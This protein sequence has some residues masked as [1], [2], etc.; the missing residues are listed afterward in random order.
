[1]ACA[2]RCFWIIP[3]LATVEGFGHEMVQMLI[4][5][6]PDSTLASI[7]KSVPMRRP[8]RQSAAAAPGGSS[9]QDRHVNFVSGLAG[10]VSLLGAPIWRLRSS[11]P[12][13]TGMT[14][15]P[16]RI[17]SARRGRVAGADRRGGYSWALID[18]WSKLTD[19]RSERHV[20]R[21]GAAF[22]GGGMQAVDVQFV[23]DFFEQAQFG[24][25]PDRRRT[26]ATSQAS[27]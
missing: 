26:P 12:I 9:R 15:S 22:D 25:R 11:P 20:T 1:M 27:A 4:R 10:L 7:L 24:C 18:R 16:T 6:G 2:I 23:A 19:S 17:E 3:A 14:P 13:S 5:L 21:T 8:D